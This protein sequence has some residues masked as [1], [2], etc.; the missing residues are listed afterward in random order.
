LL[1][2]D[3]SI[4]LS[5]KAAQVVATYD[6]TDKVTVRAMGLYTSGD[7]RGPGDVVAD[8]RYEAFVGLFPFIDATNLFFNGGIDAAFSSGSPTASGV[9]GRGVIAGVLTGVAAFDRTTLRV[10]AADL[11]SE[12]SATA[13]S[14]RHYGVE[15]DTEWAYRVTDALTAR[16]EGD[17]LFPGSFYH[18]ADPNPEPVYKLAAG[19]DLAW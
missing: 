19:V 3:T 5:G 14:G 8:Q 7:G 10:V 13:D 11:W 18:D 16:L 1:T 15:L 17:V 6:A 12:F 9:A 2:Q 4:T